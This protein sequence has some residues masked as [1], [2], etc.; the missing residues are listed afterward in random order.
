LY[1]NFKI[2]FSLLRRLESC[3]ESLKKNIKLLIQNTNET[4]EAHLKLK[5]EKE[6]QK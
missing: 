5:K 6:Y 3:G 4:F 1:L 2:F